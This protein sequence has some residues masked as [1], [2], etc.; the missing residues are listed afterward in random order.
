MTFPKNNMPVNRTIS[1]RLSRV[2]AQRRGN[3]RYEKICGNRTKRN[4]Y[5]I[6]NRALVE[7]QP[8][9]V[10]QRALQNVVYNPKRGTCHDDRKADSQIYRYDSETRKRDEY[11]WD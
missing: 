2:C 7:I 4:T 11:E 8:I 3:S 1:L 9:Y 6:T 5:T 10:V